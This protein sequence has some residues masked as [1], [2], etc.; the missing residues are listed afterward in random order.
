MDRP[1]ATFSF[2]PEVPMTDAEATLRLAALAVE[3]LHGADRIQLE[4]HVRVE[5][6]ERRF[7]V[8]IA[9][10]VGRT[11]AVIFSGYA[12]REFGDDAVRVTTGALAAAGGGK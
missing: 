3:S 12:R 5:R 8:D 1:T 6:E 4:L 11:L 2:G 7:V 10:D 9:T